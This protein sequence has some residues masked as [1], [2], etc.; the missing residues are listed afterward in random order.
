MNYHWLKFLF[1]SSYSGQSTVS[2]LQVALASQNMII[3]PTCGLVWRKLQFGQW[4]GIDGGP[5]DKVIDL[6]R[7]SLEKLCFLHNMEEL[8]KL[9]QDFIE[10]I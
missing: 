1:Q 3:D 2:T 10:K 8:Y 5:S 6:V 9:S 4:K 7:L